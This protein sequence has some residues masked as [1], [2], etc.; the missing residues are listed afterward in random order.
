MR[1]PCSNRNLTIFFVISQALATWA[2]VSGIK[3]PK[4]PILMEMRLPES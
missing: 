4:Q 1:A 3:W 2:I